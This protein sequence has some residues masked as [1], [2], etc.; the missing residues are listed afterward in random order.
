MG[1]RVPAG[2]YIKRECIKYFF[3]QVNFTMFRTT[4]PMALINNFTPVV[5]AVIIICTSLVCFC[6]PHPYIVTYS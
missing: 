5:M 3:K 2:S 6:Q 1:E 4:A